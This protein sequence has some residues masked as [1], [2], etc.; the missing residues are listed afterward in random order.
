MLIRDSKNDTSFTQNRELSWL[1][2]NERVLAEA[3][4]SAVP[5]LERLKFL[6]IFSNN[7]DEFFMIRVGSLYDLSLLGKTHLDNKSGMTA[8]EQL[9]AIYEAVLPLYG[10]RDQVFWK[11][12]EQLRQHDICNLS[13]KEL[14][15]RERKFVQE[16]FDSYVLPILSPQIVDFHH[17]FPHLEN[18]S[19]NIG[20][21]LTA[22][23]EKHFGI[24]PVPGSLPRILI[25]PG[26]SL[27]YVLVEELILRSRTCLRHVSYP[28]KNHPFS[29]KKCR[30]QSR[31][32]GL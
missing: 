22:R 23:G 7:L 4:D 24:I 18:K 16:Y 2:F 15:G 28:G 31:R 25:L 3:N 21:M 13:L 11:L 1:K 10:N 20:I 19:L 17:P 5:L 30:H 6:A 12:E 9:K 29:H 14:E 26:D 27:R 32:R 8:Q